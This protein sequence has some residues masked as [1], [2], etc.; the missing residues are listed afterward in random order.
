MMRAEGHD[1][2]RVVLAINRLEEFRV[3]LLG[4]RGKHLYFVVGYFLDVF[5]VASSH[6]VY[7][8]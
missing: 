7:R 8:G 3:D 5:A 6:S 4:A 1:V 2:E